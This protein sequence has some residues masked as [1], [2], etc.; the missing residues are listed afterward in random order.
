[1]CYIFLYSFFNVIYKHSIIVSSPFFH[2]LLKNSCKTIDYSNSQSSICEKLFPSFTIVSRTRKF[3]FVAWYYSRRKSLSWNN[4]R[5][6]LKLKIFVINYIRR[7]HKEPFVS[8]MSQLWVSGSSS[9]SSSSLLS[10]SSSYHKR[11][12]ISHETSTTD[13][14]LFTYRGDLRFIESCAGRKERRRGL[15]RPLRESRAQA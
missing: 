4:L 15:R 9:S 12:A 8:L 11:L 14:T 7:T 3:E 6:K 1:M 13:S 10:S 2:F 5:R